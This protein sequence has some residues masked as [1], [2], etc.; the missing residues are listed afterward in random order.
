MLIRLFGSGLSFGTFVAV[1]IAYLSVLLISFSA[2]E[3]AHGLT[4]YRHGDATAK[5]YGR[6]TLN[7]FAHVNTYGFVCLIMFGFGWANP[8]PINPY[9]FKKGKRS[10]F[11]VAISGILANI[12]LAM[13]F[14]FIYALL[15][16]VAP[17]AVNTSSFWGMLLQYFLMYGITINLSLAFFNLL[18]FYPLDGSKILELLIEPR[19]KFMEFLRNYS[20]VILL[21]LLLLGIVDYIVN[22]AVVF[23]GEGMLTMWTSLFDLFK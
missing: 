15:A 4:A 11:A 21:F 9:N 14:T 23:L 13:I 12:I 1:L 18:P 7:P 6:L 22:I 17:M 16:T 3:Y 20:T 10:F 2:H 5:V 8:V 19:S